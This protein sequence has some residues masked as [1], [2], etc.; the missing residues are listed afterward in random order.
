MKKLF[1]IATLFTSAAFA[2]CTNVSRSLVIGQLVSGDALDAADTF[3]NENCKNIDLDL[4]RNNLERQKR[5]AIRGE[6]L[7]NNEAEFTAAKVSK[8]EAVIGL[9]QFEELKKELV[10]RKYWSINQ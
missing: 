1:I 6:R 8:L 4:V 10:K 2:E 9:Q 3:Q 5:E 7:S